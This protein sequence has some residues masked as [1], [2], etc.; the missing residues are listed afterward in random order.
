MYLR[1]R[2]NRRNPKT[3]PGRSVHILLFQA[4][5]LAALLLAGLGASTPAAAQFVPG[6]AELPMLEGLKPE[7]DG[8]VVFDTPEGRI[9]TTSLTG[10]VDEKAVRDFYGATLAQLGWRK[11]AAGRR[12][13][14]SQY[15]AVTGQSHPAWHSRG[16]NLPPVALKATPV[17][18]IF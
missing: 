18:R 15:I 6:I 17:I 11:L 16:A 8:T 7:P 5:A 1:Y 9:V 3:G 12:K 4:A 2:K 14:A 10:A 13:S